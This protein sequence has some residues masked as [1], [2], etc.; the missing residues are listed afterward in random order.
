MDSIFFRHQCKEVS[1]QSLSGSTHLFIFP[2]P[3]GATRWNE[4]LKKECTFSIQ[5]QKHAHINGNTLN[6]IAIDRN[7]CENI[8]NVCVITIGV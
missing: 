2:F 4:K 3:I 5:V 8:R 6:G 1:V 7:M